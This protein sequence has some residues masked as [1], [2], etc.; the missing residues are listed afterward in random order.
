MAVELPLRKDR[1]HRRPRERTG[2]HRRDRKT[3]RCDSVWP[4]R[5]RGRAAER[6]PR[7]AGAGRYPYPSR[8]VAHPQPL[9][10][11]CR[12]AAGGHCGGRRRQAPSPTP[13]RP[14]FAARWGRPSAPVPCARARCRGR[15]AHRPAGLPGNSPPRRGQWRANTHGPSISGSACLPQEDL[16]NDPG[17][18]ELLV[19]ACS[20]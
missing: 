16:L 1:P 11:R 4:H 17:V 6:P 7:R 3:G 12:Y 19:Q 5:C 8:Q 20:T 15:S 2:R 18:E 14:A 10:Q 9:P 13:S